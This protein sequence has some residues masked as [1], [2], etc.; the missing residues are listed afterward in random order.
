MLIFHDQPTRRVELY[1]QHIVS[2]MTN[3]ETDEIR[4]DILRRIPQAKK[5]PANNIT[6]HHVDRVLDKD[7]L[8]ELLEILR[9]LW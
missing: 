3:E 4:T 7:T 5:T 9:K 1:L 2:F 6:I 8:Y